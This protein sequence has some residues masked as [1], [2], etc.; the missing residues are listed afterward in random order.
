[1]RQF[2]LISV[3]FSI[4]VFGLAPGN[5]EAKAEACSDSRQECLE[6]CSRSGGD[7]PVCNNGS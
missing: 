5:V 2:F 7:C 4:L 1:M 3:V 6:P